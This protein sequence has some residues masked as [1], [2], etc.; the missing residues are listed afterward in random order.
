M[1]IW[2]HQV[3]AGRH[4][5]VYYTE[6][7][8]EGPAYFFDILDKWRSL[9]SATWGKHYAPHDAQHARYGEDGNVTTFTKICKKLGWNFEPV[10]RTLN[11]LN[12]IQ[13][14][15]N[16]IPNCEFDETGSGVGLLHLETYSK[17]WDDRLG[18]W[19]NDERHDEHSHAAHAFMT[20]TDGYKPPVASKPLVYPKNSGIV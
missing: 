6:N 12:S 3:V 13:V 11:L 18:V 4:R 20:F 19:K 2:V 9:H 17:E 15:R 5:F 7:S 8:G 10:P 1:S 16:Q 14:A